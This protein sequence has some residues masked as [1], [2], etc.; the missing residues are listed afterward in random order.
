[1]S[2]EI[3]F[4]GSFQ[5]VRKHEQFLEFLEAT[6]SFEWTAH[7]VTTVRKKSREQRSGEKITGMAEN[8]MKF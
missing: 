7:V 1:M 3:S 2:F 6:G 8:V 5:E 4:P